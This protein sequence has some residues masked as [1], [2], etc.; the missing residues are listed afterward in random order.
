[1]ARSREWRTDS[2][3]M[4]RTIHESIVNNGAHI[5][6][7]GAKDFVLFDAADNLSGPAV[8]LVSM[9]LQ[10]STIFGVKIHAAPLGGD[11]TY[12]GLEKWTATD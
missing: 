2:G 5:G 10:G 4:S 8:D 1:M 11:H 6:T 9:N 7:I 3:T 12:G